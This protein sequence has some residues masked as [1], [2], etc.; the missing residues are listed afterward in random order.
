MTMMNEDLA[1]AFDQALAVAY[2]NTPE[3]QVFNLAEAGVPEVPALGVSK[4]QHARNL[5]DMH[6]H[7]GCLEIGLCLRGAL[8]LLNNGAKHRIM[9]GDLFLNKAADEHGIIVNPKGTVVNWL[10][11]RAPG[12]RRFLRLDSIETN[13]LWTRLNELPC[14]FS[15]KTDRVKHAFGL[16][17]KYQ[18]QPPSPFRS[19]ALTTTVTSLLIDIVELS[20][21]KGMTSHAARIETLT[22]RIR[23]HPEPDFSLNDLAR[24]ARLS[25]SQ[26]IAEFKQIC[27]LPPLQYQL[28]C[29][30]E[31]GRLLLEET[32]QPI[33]RIA[34]D[35]G[36]CASQHFSNHFK[37]AFGVSPKAWRGRVT[38]THQ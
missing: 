22:R 7:S 3:Q 4:Y 23:E 32:S 24:E 20:M 17:F 18:A 31:K 6:R 26:L 35:L 15:A 28:A 2:V 34:F 16:L 1:P 13:D 21:K 38:S 30:L 36:F 8:T 25:S 29:R 19:L 37:R 10:L 33:T 9:P 11:L 5:M 27:G 12:R 14:H